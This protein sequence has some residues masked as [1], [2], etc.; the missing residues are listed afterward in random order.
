MSNYMV[1]YIGLYRKLAE[2]DLWLSEKFSRGQAWVDLLL[3]ARFKPGFIRVAGV[4]IDLNRGD[5]GWSENA[6]ATRWRWSRTKVRSFISELEEDERIVRNTSKIKDK[7]KSIV[8]ICNYDQYQDLSGE[9]KASDCTIEKQDKNNRKAS[10]CT[11]EDTV[12]KKVEEGKKE[13]NKTTTAASCQDNDSGDD[14]GGSGEG[15]IPLDGKKEEYRKFASGFYTFLAEKC[16]GK[17][18]ISERDLLKAVDT[19]DKLVRLDE[20]DWE[21]E[22][23][24]AIRW[25]VKDQFWGKQV[26]SLGP[27][28]EKSKNNGL[29]KFENLFHSFSASSGPSGAATPMDPRNITEAK[30]MQNNAV[31]KMLLEKRRARNAGKEEGADKGS[32]RGTGLLVEPT[33]QGNFPDPRRD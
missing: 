26:R 12:K 11:I 14:G 7:R 31:A 25:A 21:T 15:T 10:D 27:L 9:T 32:N 1:G 13:K 6:L 8:T 16:G 4:R 30:I 18:K 3:L 29:K 5:V 28:R 33:V 17:K 23:Q 2:S 22:V 20:Y 24:P 19:L